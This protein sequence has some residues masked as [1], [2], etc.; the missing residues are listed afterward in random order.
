MRPKNF[1]RRIPKTSDPRMTKEEAN[2][3]VQSYLAINKKRL[4]S[5]N[6]DMIVWELRSFVPGIDVMLESELRATVSIW[7]SLNGPLF[8]LSTTP[9]PT[10]PE[11]KL[12]ASVKSAVTTVIQGV[13]LKHGD[14]KI[15]ISVTGLTAEL[16][17]QGG[18]ASVGVSWGGTLAVEANKGD[19]HFAGELSSD[20]W[21]ITLSYPEDTAVPDLSKLGKIFGEGEKAMRGIVS[22]TSD[23]KSLHDAARVKE[24]LAPHMLPVSEAVGAAKGIA[25]APAKGG[26]SL[27]LTFGSPDPLPGATG[28]P[29]GIQGQIT[30]TVTF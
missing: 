15:N 10:M 24:A 17:K 18:S 19:F 13:D 1:A 8:P 7:R 9:P 4:E 30:L 12:I 28:M 6:A 29:R 5:H 27:G 23:F 14:G 25:K 3:K 26:V 11:S 16:S 2:L 21:Q 20:R 22:A